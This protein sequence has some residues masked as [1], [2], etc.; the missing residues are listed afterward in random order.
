MSTAKKNINKEILALFSGQASIV[1]TPKLY[2]QLTGSHTLA[3]VLNQCVFWANKSKS[4]DGWFYKEYQEWFDEI[5][6][7]ERTLRRRFDRLEQNGWITTK[8]KKVRGINIKH[9]HTNIDHIIE[10]IS[11]MLNTDFPDR[12]LC[13]DG[14]NVIPK[15]CTNIAPTGQSGR[16]EPAK[17]ADSRARVLY[18][19][20]E[21]L[22]KKTTNCSSSSFFFSETIDLEILNTK[23]FRDERSDEDFMI[24]A[25]HH[26]DNHS[27]KQHPRLV[28]AQALLKLLKKLKND[29]VIFYAKGLAP[30]ENS[31]ATTTKTKKSP[32]T[33]EELSLVSEYKH[34]V[35]FNKLDLF[36]PDLEKREKAVEIIATM[37]AME[38]KS[39]QNQSPANNAR[40]NSLTSAS[41]LVSHLNLSQRGS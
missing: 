21:N 7:P 1:T 29:N 34:A 25:M 14:S 26:V 13:P 18:I 6:I 16:L 10:S 11:N 24:H 40:K 33:E 2:I 19:A 38:A 23:L 20:E 15:T 39:C 41:N 27:D 30:K 12:P 8:I 36:M 17:L 35:K 5:H 37:K 4:S 22:Q 9:I 31:K 28:R 32:F 3:T